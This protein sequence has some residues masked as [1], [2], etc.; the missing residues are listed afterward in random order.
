[1]IYK[2]I[3]I[4][5]GEPYSTF[6]EI[7][8]KTYKRNI[9]S[10]L[11]RPIIFIGSIN[12][13]QKQMKKLKYSFKINKLDPNNINTKK[14]NKNVLN[15]ID[16]DFKFN[17]TFDKISYKSKKHIKKSFDIAINLLK[18]KKYSGLINGPISKKH[19]LKKK[20]PGITE[21]LK[22]LSKTNSN[23]AMLIY[24]P[25]L[26][27]SPITTH[28]PIKDVSKKINKKTIISNII[29]INKFFIKNLKRKP[30]IAVL[31]LN[32]HCETTSKFSEEDKIIIPAIK[33]LLKKN[34]EVSGPFPADTFFL[35]KNI[36]K[37]DV[38]I[39][40][41]HDQVL[42]PIKTLYNF[43]AINITAGLN[44]LR[45]SPDHGTNNG[46]IGLNKS[47]CSSFISTLNF[48]NKV[49]VN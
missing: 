29:S 35:K 10:N 4:V 6:Q 22:K 18:T 45:A 24:N 27:V 36:K 11:K 1:M 31:G 26:S 38:V 48:F 28:V 8:F 19:F 37:F 32:P 21:Y 49:N 5:V 42:V 23:V 33:N 40:M 30:K 9:I 7:I 25:E 46:M 12:L 47:N 43:E 41:Y 15:F 13:F 17:K 34:I 2:P 39:G 3:I 20:Y 44:F 14:I 16:V